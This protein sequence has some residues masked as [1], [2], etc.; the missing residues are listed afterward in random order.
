MV[1]PKRPFLAGA[2]Y[3]RVLSNPGKATAGGG[4][5]LGL[6]CGVNSIGDPRTIRR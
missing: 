1:R 3:T 5:R 4:E 2:S 6:S